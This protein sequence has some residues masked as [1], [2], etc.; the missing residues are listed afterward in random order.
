MPY[1]ARVVLL[2]EAMLLVFSVTAFAANDRERA[3]QRIVDVM[4][5][6]FLRYQIVGPVSARIYMSGRLWNG[7]SHDEQQQLMDELASK[8]EV[9][10]LKNSL[11][12]V[13]GH[14]EV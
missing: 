2:A 8:E 5:P 13:V 1:K 10:S 6:L 9:Q 4:S 14:T 3:L 12:L 7:L 11:H